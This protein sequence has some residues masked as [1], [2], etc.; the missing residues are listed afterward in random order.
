MSETSFSMVGKSGEQKPRRT[1]RRMKTAIRCRSKVPIGERR[2][3]EAI[4]AELWGGYRTGIVAPVVWLRCFVTLL[5]F[6]VFDQLCDITRNS[7]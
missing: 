2:R 1:P 5:V 7:S 6:Y 3:R 4:D